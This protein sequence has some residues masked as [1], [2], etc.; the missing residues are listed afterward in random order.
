MIGVAAGVASLIIALSINAGF[1][2]D[3]QNQLLGAQSHVQLQRTA[4]DGISDWRNLM[5][6]VEKSP[7]VVAAAPALY[8][9]V[10]ASRGS[11]ASGMEL[12]GVVPEYENRV[13][14]LLKS[15][16][17]GSALPLNPQIPCHEMTL[18][19]TTLQEPPP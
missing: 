1:Q 15:V 7:H 13:S 14:E 17:I 10:L 9:Q 2:R 12:K 18:D 11:R 19:C 6:R 3:L 16:K 8:D 4:N 5:A